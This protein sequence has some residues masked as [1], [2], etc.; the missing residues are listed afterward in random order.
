M[1]LALLP[2]HPSIHLYT[3][4]LRS[5]FIYCTLNELSIC[6]SVSHHWQSSVLSSRC[7]GHRLFGGASALIRHEMLSAR[8]RKHVSQLCTIEEDWQI[9]NI[10][11]LADT[12]PHLHI[13]SIVLVCPFVM[14]NVGQFPPQLRQ[15]TVRMPP[16]TPEPEGFMHTLRAIA[17]LTHLTQLTICS[18]GNRLTESVCSFEPLIQSCSLQHLIIEG[19][20]TLCTRVQME[21]FRRIPKL[22]SIS[23]EHLTPALMEL[24]LKPPHHLQWKQIGS[25]YNANEQMISLLS[26]LPSVTKLNLCE[27]VSPHV[28]SL[29]NLP[30]LSV[31]DLG[32]AT[33][34][35]HY[36]VRVH[37]SRILTSVQHCSALTKLT[38]FALGSRPSG[39]PICWTEH[40]LADLF[41]HLTHL[42][43][44]TLARPERIRSLAFLAHAPSLKS[45]T[46]YDHLDKSKCTLPMSELI[47]VFALPALTSF[48][49]SPQLFHPKLT[50]SSVLNHS[51]SIPQ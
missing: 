6:M 2:F 32:F 18:H 9:G 5:V 11:R 39:K 29:S 28:D 34:N 25:L 23:I 21:Q 44:F 42:H 14:I 16:S 22:E 17:D 10:H 20:L 1:S 27:L 35:P 30:H 50:N 4:A 8:L 49:I 38:L 12:M 37:V 46:L 36:H 3:D 51:I 43:E 47:H 15:L 24:L 33:V 7:C 48:Y 19:P 40:Q 45:F 31:L 13:L 26:R 41:H